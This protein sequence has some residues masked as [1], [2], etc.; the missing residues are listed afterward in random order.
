MDKRALEKRF[1]WPWVT[2]WFADSAMT[3]QGLE[4]IT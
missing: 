2:P 3:A 1:I 4:R